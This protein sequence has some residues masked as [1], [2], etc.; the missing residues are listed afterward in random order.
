MSLSSPVPPR[1]WPIG[2]IVSRSFDNSD[3][4]TT[5]LSQHIESISHVHTNGSQPGSK[6]VEDFCRDNK[7]TYTVH[8]STRHAFVANNEVI[9]RSSFVYIITDGQSKA[10]KHAEE[11]CAAKPVKFRVLHYDP[12]TAWKQKVEWAREILSGFPE[13][14]EDSTDSPEI[15]PFREAIEAIRKVLK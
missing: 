10:A 4:L 2:I 1:K 13:P 7:L 5:V 12:V 8:P 3:L 11:Q 6:L 14:A 15:A 9:D